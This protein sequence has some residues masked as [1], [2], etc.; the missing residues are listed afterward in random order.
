MEPNGGT[1]DDVRRAL[2]GT[3]LP[4]AE[5]QPRLPRAPGLY[6]W[7]ASP[8]VL[9]DFPGTAHPDTPE[10]RLLYLGITTR[11]L[12]SRVTAE[13]L[14]QSRRSTLRRTL[15]ALL[16]ADEGYRTRREH[17]HVVLTG[18]DEDRLTTW[19]RARLRLTWAGHHDPRPVETAL[20]AELAPPLNL[21]GTTPTTIRSRLTAARA[22]YRASADGTGHD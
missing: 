5:A 4:L 3:P 1:R 2:L 18:D 14:R 19:M 13:H 12:R 10:L 21:A 11:T 17:G 9:P 20:L 7:W 16:M 15:A 6:A 8:D 22:A